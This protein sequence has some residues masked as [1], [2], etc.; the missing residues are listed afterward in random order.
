MPKPRETSGIRSVLLL[1]FLSL[2]SSLTAILLSEAAVRFFKPQQLILLRP[3][4]WCPRDVLGWTHC[5]NV[6]TTVNS[7]EGEVTFHT[8]ANG[9][10]IDPATTMTSWNKN[11]LILG[12]SFMEAVQVDDRNTTA[13]QLSRQLHAATGLNVKAVNT[14]VAQW[15]PNQ[16]LL[17]AQLELTRGKYDLGLV[18]IYLGNDIVPKAIEHFP[19]RQPDLRRQ[20]A[21]ETYPLWGKVRDRILYPMNDFLRTSSH[22]FLF[23]KKNTSNILMRLRLS[24]TAIPPVFFKDKDKLPDWNVTALLCQRIGRE[25]NRRRTPVIF[26]LIPT[27]FQVDETAFKSYLA[28]YRISPTAVDSMQPNRILGNKLRALH[29]VVL[30]PLERFKILTAQG[31]QLY[32]HADNHLNALGYEEL[33][34]AVAPVARQYLK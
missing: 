34:S 21:M 26:V 9:F 20:V 3:D 10:R 32:G 5:P 8:D 6:S 22:L 16:Y 23:I 15:D 11:I 4:I 29:L 1:I 18:F 7:G 28:A 13:E 2:V 27:S 30:D 14:G 31:H 12:D 19:P 33:A 17:Q 25:F 24:G